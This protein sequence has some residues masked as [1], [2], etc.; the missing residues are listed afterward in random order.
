MSNEFEPSP[1]DP[2]GKAVLRKVSL[3]LIP[4]LFLL[5][6]VNLIDRTNVSMAKLQMFD[7]ERA[8]IPAH[9]FGTLAGLFYIGYLLFE[10][11]SNLILLRVGAR[12]WIARIVVAWGLVSMGMMFVTGPIGFAVLRL[13]LGVAEAGFFPGIIFYLSQWFPERTRGRAVAMFMTGGVIAPMLGNPLSGAIMTHLDGVGDLWGWQW[14]FLL[15]GVPSVILGLI[16][17]RVL[18]DRPET[19]RWLTPA[20][21]DWLI[22]ERDKS[23]HE[24]QPHTLK[25]AF[26]DPKVWLLIA[27]YFTISVGENVYGFFA[28]SLLKKQF[29]AWAEDEIGY[30]AAVPYLFALAAMVLVGRHSDRTGERRWH[31]AGSAFTAAGGW[32]ILVFAPSPW[33]SVVGMCVTLVGMKSM[34][35][36]F[37]TLP[38]S[39]LRG[40]AAAG[41]VALINSLANVGGYFGPDAF[42]RLEKE[43]GSYLLGLKLIAGILFLGGLLTLSM[44]RRTPEATK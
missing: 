28:P 15:E 30:L 19:A 4:F 2:T 11:P 10:V 17:L 21:R 14:V 18:P 36:T 42:G 29:P 13:L 25:A 39:M 38:S 7:G 24:S 20:E 31:V 5:Y 27:I 9:L 22:G 8:F 3:R 40:T 43:T 23:T 41:G 1:S 33:V 44:R 37:W 32:L 26:L 12:V 35:P 6:V 16:T 34:L